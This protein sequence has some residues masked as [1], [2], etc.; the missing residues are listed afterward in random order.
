VPVVRP[1]GLGLGQRLLPDT[2]GGRA[3]GTV[4]QTVDTA[5]TV[6]RTSPPIDR[7]RRRN[8]TSRRWSHARRMR[9]ARVSV[10]V[11]SVRGI[12]SIT[13]AVLL[14]VSIIIAGLQFLAHRWLRGPAVEQW[15][16]ADVLSLSCARLVADG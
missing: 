9:S 15:S 1:R 14:S 2:A 3:R 11:A 12:S 7:C 16:L 5:L 8:V 6:R 10:M 4:W 13:V